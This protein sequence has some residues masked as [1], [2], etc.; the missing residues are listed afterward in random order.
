MG[1]IMDK[2]VELIKQAVD[3]LLECELLEG[4]GWTKQDIE[5]LEKI[6]TEDF[7]ISWVKG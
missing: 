3:R 2:T 1:V 5:T 6:S 4:N 7:A